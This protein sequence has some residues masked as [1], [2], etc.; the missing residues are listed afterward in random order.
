M[1]V[2]GS[3]EGKSEKETL[4]AQVAHVKEKLFEDWTKLAKEEWDKEFIWVSEGGVGQGVYL[5]PVLKLVFMQMV[6][7]LLPTS[8]CD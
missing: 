3:S 7:R 4:G 2:Y 6:R 8:F 1:A 5:G